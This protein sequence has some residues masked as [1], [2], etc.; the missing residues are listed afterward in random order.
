MFAG[1][2]LAG[3]AKAG[4]DLIGNQQN[5]LAVAHPANTPQPFRMVH[6]HSA[7]ALHNRLQDHGG[8]IMTMCRHE[9]R[10][11]NHVHLVPLVVEAALRGRR[12]E[13]FRQI[14]FPQAVHG[15][16]RVTDRHR[17][18][19]ITMIAVAEREEALARFA[20]GVP[21]LQRHFHRH[22]HRH[23]AGIGQEHALQRFRRHRHQATA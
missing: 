5:A 9:S 11:A 22:F 7:C 10:E 21:V 14:P 8:D 19:G 4:G 12:E 2:Q 20:S 3:A 13:V 1:K 18:E 23:G 17:P 6:P 16:I 15:V